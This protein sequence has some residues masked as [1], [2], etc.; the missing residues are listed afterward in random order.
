M[1]GSEAYNGGS[2]DTNFTF[3]LAKD[4]GSCR[5]VT[6]FFDLSEPTLERW[7]FTWYE[8]LFAQDAGTP[9]LVNVASKAYRNLRIYDAGDCESTLDWHTPAV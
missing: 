7:N 2:P 6:D 1:N 9:S 4:G 8:D 3:C 5:G